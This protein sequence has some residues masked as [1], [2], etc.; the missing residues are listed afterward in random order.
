MTTC[1]AKVS[2]KPQSSA[3]PSARPRAAPTRPTAM[4][5]KHPRGALLRTTS[6]ASAPMTMATNRPDQRPL[7][8]TGSASQSRLALGSLGPV[9]Q[10]RHQRR[11]RSH[12]WRHGRRSDRRCRPPSRRR[13]GVLV[14]A[15]RHRPRAGPGHAS[16]E[17]VRRP[18]RTGPRTHSP[19]RRGAPVRAAQLRATSWTSWSAAAS[20][21]PA[22]ASTSASGGRV[23]GSSA[24]ASARR[25][26][27]TSRRRSSGARTSRDRGPSGPCGHV[28]PRVEGRGEQHRDD[29]AC[30]GRP[31]A[32]PSPPSS[33]A[34]SWWPSHPRRVSPQR[35]STA[36]RRSSMTAACRGSGLPCAARTTGMVR[37]WQ[38][39]R[40]RP[41]RVRRA[42]ARR[43]PPRRPPARR[44]GAAPRRR[45]CRRASRRSCAARGSCRAPR[46][47]RGSSAAR[48]WATSSEAATR[49]RP[50]PMSRTRVPSSAA[51][52]AQSTSWS[53]ADTT[54]KPRA[55]P[56]WVTGMPAKAG[57]ATAEVTPGT[58]STA[59]PAATQARASSPPATEHVGVAALEADDPLALLGAVD[60]ERP[61]SRAGSGCGRAAPC[62]RR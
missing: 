11:V 29:D 2:Q 40:V 45:R 15:G 3:D 51:R 55:S 9:A 52:E 14:R 46:P 19:P 25:S 60:D 47:P 16:A 13:G 24:R 57:T 6:R 35:C 36:T 21:E 53:W 8:S 22:A 59:T 20:V 18:R 1:A 38:V 28:D 12:R 42:A 62:P 48:P 31:G 41:D 33:R 34:G 27:R 49:R 7:M 44:P 37:A 61:R 10:H 26:S 58:T 54:V 50:T 5:R 39:G 23:P 17:P 4:V 56:R 43:R 32:R 30:A